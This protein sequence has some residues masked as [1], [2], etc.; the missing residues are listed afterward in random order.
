[1]KLWDLA[2]PRCVVEAAGGRFTAL[3][4]TPTA[5]GGSALAT[6]GKLHDELLG[7]SPPDR[8]A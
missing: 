7:P 4:G 6:N 2:A 5:D 3:D 8:S 1:V